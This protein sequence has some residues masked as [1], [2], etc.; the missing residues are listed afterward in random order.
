[1]TSNDNAYGMFAVNGIFFNHESPRRGRTF[2]I[3]KTT[4][5]VA[6]I[7]SG[8]QECLYLGNLDASRDWGHAEDHVEGMW[9]ILNHQ[10]IKSP[11]NVT[12]THLPKDYVLSSNETHTVREI[13]ELS[14]QYARIGIVW[15]G[16]SV[17]EIGVN[18]E[19]PS[20]V[21]VRIDPK[22]YRPTEVDLLWGI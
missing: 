18:V 20:Q 8:I 12:I 13:V 5:A 11:Q 2:V 19:N 1:M 9:R 10:E 17:N 21:L 15:K 16:E 3:R 14:F 7:K 22:Y 4:R 6:R